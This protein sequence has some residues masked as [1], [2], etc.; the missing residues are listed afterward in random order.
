MGEG[1]VGVPA[2]PSICCIC[3]VLIGAPAKSSKILSV[4]GMMW[5]R[6]NAAPSRAPASWSFRQHSHSSVAQPG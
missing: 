1:S 3:A 4:T 5:S 2:M 6:M